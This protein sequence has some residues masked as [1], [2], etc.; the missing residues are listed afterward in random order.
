MTEKQIADDLEYQYRLFGAKGAAFP[1]IVAVG[2]V[3]LC[4]TPRPATPDSKKANSSWSIGGQ[5]GSLSERLDAD[6]GDG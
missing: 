1:S 6:D 3:P 5:R 2:P 4:R